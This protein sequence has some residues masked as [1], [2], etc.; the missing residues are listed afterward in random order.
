MQTFAGYVTCREEFESAKFGA[1]S[2]DHKAIRALGDF[3]GIPENVWPTCP[4]A[5][6]HEGK[7][8]PSPE[9]VY[10]LLHHDF[11]AKNSFENLLVRYLLAYSFGYGVRAPSELLTL[12][13]MDLDLANHIVTVTE[14]K[15]NKSGRRRRIVVEPEWL[16]CSRSRLS[17][18]NWV[19]KRTN[20]PGTSPAV[21]VRENGQPFT[22]PDALAVFLKRTV[23][24][25]FPW[26]TCYVARHWSCNAR[27]IQWNLDWA[28]VAKW[29]GHRTTKMAM[30]TYAPAVEVHR[31]L[32]GDEWLERAFSRNRDTNRKS[33]S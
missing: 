9:Q 11:F 1:L 17:L 28:R 24:P 33:G 18:E 26:Y 4:P 23:Q 2:N 3:L 27:A 25:E 5:P 13:L 7:Q 10:E 29:H 31:K 20:L 32:Y 16:C 6:E 12:S 21:F 22:N 30:S 14:F 19:A 15:T 8:V